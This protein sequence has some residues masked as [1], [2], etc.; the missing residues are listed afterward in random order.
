MTPTYIY[1]PTGAYAV[2]AR[3]TDTGR[4]ARLNRGMMTS[5]LKPEPEPG[6]DRGQ[7]QDRAIRGAMWTILNT[8]IS[9]PVA[10]VVNLLLARILGIVDY[11]RLAFLTAFMEMATTVLSVGIGIG[12]L[13]FGAKAH[14][15]GRR[16][17]V[18]GLLARA[19]G[20]KLIWVAPL[21]SIL[22]I[23]VADVPVV[24]LVIAVVFGI[25]L[26]ASLSGASASLGIENKTATDARI[27]MIGNLLTQLAVVAILFTVSTSDAVWS[28]RLIVAGLVGALALLVISKDYRRAILRPKIPRGFPEG[29]WRFALPAGLA[30]LIASLVVSRSE[31]FL[32]QAMSSPIA[33]GTFALAVGLSTHLFAPAQALV[34][35]LIPA[36][37]GLREV[38]EDSVHRAF[39]RTI[40]ASSTVVGLLVAGA[41]PGLTVL[42]PLLY[43]DEYA[44]VPAMLIVLGTTGGLAMIAV[45]VQAFVL[46]RLKG[47]GVLWVNVAALAV[48]VVLAVSLIPF[49][50]AWGAVIAMASAGIVRL[51]LF[52]ASE[53]RSSDS[54]SWHGVMRCLLPAVIGAAAAAIGW[55][56]SQQLQVPIIV[57]ACLAS[58]IALILLAVGLRMTRS[59]LTTDDAKAIAQSVPVAARGGALKALKIV[60]WSRRG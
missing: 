52:L 8:A 59:G 9:L 55:G 51:V 4:S 2:W 57:A 39:I 27:Q 45:P 42:V 43:G 17:A 50:G 44:H 16:E 7:L 54:A 29:F 3:R 21:L 46:S 58:A 34:Y 40:R 53:I 25:W 10:F 37:S 1:L 6:L 5:E 24:L 60:T 14:A 31:I 30:S 22:V 19:Q 47:T 12:V 15:S 38:D 49:M 11:G 48:D 23:A 28:I 13:Q 20:L 32:L 41:L 33:V 26:P 56:L 18:R 35:P 36:V